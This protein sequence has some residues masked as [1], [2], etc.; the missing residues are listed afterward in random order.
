MKKIYR[1]VADLIFDRGAFQFGAFKLKLH[2]KNPDA[3]LSPFFLNLRSGDNPKPGPL[4]S[5]DFDLIARAL[6]EKTT[7]EGLS[8]QAIVGIPNAG[9]PIIEAIKRLVPTPRGFRVIKLFKEVLGGKRKI[10]PLPGFEYWNNEKVLVFDDLITKADSKIEAIKAIESKGS[11]VK[12]LLVLVDRQQ[13]GQ[14]QLKNAG[15]N[16]VSC[17]TIRQ[18]LN[19]YKAT[20]KISGQ[21]YQE[22]ISYIEN[23]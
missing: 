23:N 8:F 14:A 19:Y 16:L 6:W 1:E 20:G 21:K 12:N 7:E 3:P 18:V 5:V 22:C 4:A 9:D 10:I 2:E 11:I 13:G 17:F 15:Y